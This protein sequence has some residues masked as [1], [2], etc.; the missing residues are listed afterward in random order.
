M[1]SKGRGVLDTP[2]SQGYDG[3]H[4][5]HDVRLIIASS[6]PS[7]TYSAANTALAISAVPLRPPNSI[8]LMPSA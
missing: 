8:G 4:P 6:T 2:L 7:L 5:G 3:S 1:E